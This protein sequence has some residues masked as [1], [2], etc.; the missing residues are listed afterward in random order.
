MGQNLDD[1]EIIQVLHEGPYTQIA[2]AK[3]KQDGSTVILKIIW[4]EKINDSAIERL[5]TEFSL[6]QQINSPYVIKA[7]D[8]FSTTAGTALV[9]ENFES[10]TLADYIASEPWDLLR[11]LQI[12]VQITEALGEIHQKNIIHKDIKPHN[13]LIDKNQHTKL[14]DLSS[15]TFL[16]REMPQEISVS[17]LEGTLAYISPEQTSRLARMVDYRTDIYSLGVTLY[18]LFTGKVPFESDNTLGLIHLHLTQLP[19]P[20]CEVNPKIPKVL[21]DI[22]LKCMKKNAEDRYKSA[23]GLLLDLQRCFSDL[24]KTGAI[25]D[26]TPGES[27]FYDR[28]HTP[29]KLYGREK[30]L[31]IVKECIRKASEGNLVLLDITGYSGIGKSSLVLEAVKHAIQ[32]NAR[33]VRYKFDQFNKNIPNDAIATV[34]KSLVHHILAQPD[35]KLA[36]SRNQ[37]LDVV[38]NNGQILIDLVPD[39]KLIIGEQPPLDPLSPQESENRFNYVL[40]EFMKV[41][42]RKDSPLI[43]MFDDIQWIDE[44]SLKVFKYLLTNSS[45]KYTLIVIA[46]RENEISEMHPLPQLLKDFVSG[47]LQLT[48][49]AVPPLEENAVEEILNEVF[50]P[51]PKTELKYLSRLVEDK[52]HG[53]PFFV[54]QFLKYLY[55]KEFIKFKPTSLQWSVDIEGASSLSV[56]DNVID[57]LL[58]KIK[59]IDNDLLEF[60]KT[61]ALFG[62]RFNPKALIAFWT[63]SHFL[64]FELLKKGLQEEYIVESLNIGNEEEKTTYQ[65]THDRLQQVF[66]SLIDESQKPLLHYA[67]G[68]CLL[69]LYSG[70]EL[71]EHL[72]S[73]VN[74]LN[75]GLTLDL[76][77]EQ[78]RELCKLNN[79]AGIKA[80]DAQ[81][82]LSAI[83]YFNNG[84]KLLEDDSWKRDFQT[85]Y[86]LHRKLADCLHYVG[87]VELAKKYFNLCLEHAQ[88]L[89]E[90]I[91]VYIGLMNISVQTGDFNESYD[92]A[93]RAF[94]LLDFH[95]NFNPGKLLIVYQLISLKIKMHFYSEEQLKQL[96]D[97]TS[98]RGRLITAVLSPLITAA[99][100]GAKRLIVIS[101]SI[102]AAGNA[103]K[104]GVSPH[105][106]QGLF[107]YGL[108]LGSEKVADYAGCVKMGRFGNYLLHRYTNFPG[109]GFAKFI[110]ANFSSRWELPMRSISPLFKE[111]ARDAMSQGNIGAAVTSL[112][113]SIQVKLFSGTD[114]QTLLD[115][116]L[117]LGPEAKK[118]S[119]FAED[120]CLS[121]YREMIKCLMGINKDPVN[122]IADEFA[123]EVVDDSIVVHPIHLAYYNSWRSILLFFF[124]EY[125]KTNQLIELPEMIIDNYAGLQSTSML[126]LTTS[127]SMSATMQNPQD[128]TLG[129][130][131][132]KKFYGILKK[133]GL[134]MPINYGPQMWLVEGEIARIEGN[135]QKALDCYDSAIDMARQEENPLLSGIAYETVA[136]YFIKRGKE[137]L[138]TF[139][140]EKAL[141]CF[142]HLHA[143]AKVEHILKHYEHYFSSAKGSIPSTSLDPKLT[144]SHH[145]THLTL[146]TH[147]S[148]PTHTTKEENNI[149]LST[150]IKAAESLSKEI[151]S[152]KLSEALMNLMIES[153]GATRALLIRFISN[154]PVVYSEINAGIPYTA[155][156]SPVPISLKTKDLC[157]NIVEYVIRTKSLIVLNDVDT[158]PGNFRNDPYFLWSKPKAILCIPL[159]QSSEIKAI[160]YLENTTTTNTFMPAQ[161]QLLSI[162]SSQM[163]ISLENAEFYGKLEEKVALRT[164]E[165][166]TKNKELAESNDQ[167]QTAFKHIQEVHERM[168]Q[169]EKMAS[170]GMLTAGIAHELKNPLNFVINFSQIAQD[171]LQSLIEEIESGN[172]EEQQSL[173]K[174]LVDNLKTIDLQGSRANRIIKEMLSQ[175]HEGRG[176]LEAININTL[177]DESFKLAYHAFKKK[178]PEIRQVQIQKHYE[179]NL[180]PAEGFPG[181]IMRV[182]INLIDNACYAMHQRQKKSDESY[183][184]T[185]EITTK[186][187]EKAITIIIKDNGI[188]IPQEM[189]DKVYNPFFTTKATGSGTGLG[190]WITF[191]IITKK[192][193]GTIEVE[194]TP[195]QFTQFTIT[196]KKHTGENDAAAGNTTP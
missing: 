7:L 185:L 108:V 4:P 142:E 102:T 148:H 26:F 63:K 12:S 103:L 164:Q 112:Y 104:Y 141:N 154:V 173:V 15:G 13:I 132:I 167:L 137:D 123:D 45:I 163:L 83:T 149:D 54:L 37:I 52:T 19:V 60:L 58:E 98:Q 6:L 47:G 144:T 22:I 152:V 10:K 68:E 56:S 71:D 128:N 14:I 107:G 77:Q 194:S 65:F 57:F 42:P 9:L 159:M 116:A 130:K 50:Y 100:K 138:V 113:C 92:F 78:Q 109:S 25:T 16:A 28:F 30:E 32:N 114:L 171:N 85:T 190:L 179:Q 20:P 122:P 115:E 62:N 40:N 183:I 165:L 55:D 88:D 168:I 131:K 38:G 76:S 175:A 143:K 31:A 48:H 193:Q 79:M 119:A 73:I 89:E 146:T 120:K 23:F 61:C 135:N 145:T 117:V 3:A 133:M 27:D 124:D 126:L 93:N 67:L 110:Y 41:A 18:H 196:L 176:T 21:S 147:S 182:F 161:L 64:V 69:K 127:L 129:W 90:K 95:F 186:S 139:Y 51:L 82:F 188:G 44:A 125:E 75:Y 166:N 153:A 140:L 5:L 99:Y 101:G 136:R 96:T 36:E 177:L 111:A 17:K 87:Q 8:Y 91:N 105:T 70:R 134:A 180:P 170:L 35:E 192:H 160:L 187:D 81:A 43:L 156:K 189:M 184:P 11:R 151:D 97:M 172:K 121:L 39:M 157:I 66:Y 29:Q 49:L 80:K 1:F 86:Q 33:F 158:D 2:R 169:Q 178:E 155:L 174:E 74:H 191:D 94:K 24:Y 195:D 118:L 150:V 84:I 181:D 162:L 46:Y 72:V 59:T 53:N 106:I 34:I